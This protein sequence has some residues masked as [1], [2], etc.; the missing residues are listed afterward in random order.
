MHLTSVRPRIV[1]LINHTFHLTAKGGEVT[2][3]ARAGA[4]TGRNGAVQ[5][6]LCTKSTVDYKMKRV[7]EVETVLAQLGLIASRQ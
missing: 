5:N 7:G 3:G 2:S 6:K 4:N 1:I